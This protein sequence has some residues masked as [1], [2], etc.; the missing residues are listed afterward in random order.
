LAPTLA[1]ERVHVSVRGS[2]VRVSVHAFN[3]AS[4]VDRLLEVL[5][6]ALGRST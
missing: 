6:A 1:A 5:G 2:A 3:T 4:D